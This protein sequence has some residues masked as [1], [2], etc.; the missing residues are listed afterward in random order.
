MSGA[1]VSVLSVSAQQ[2]GFSTR[3]GGTV[4]WAPTEASLVRG[5]VTLQ[6]AI[7]S[8]CTQFLSC[9]RPILR[10]RVTQILGLDEIDDRVFGAVVGRLQSLGKVSELL[11]FS[12]TDKVFRAYY[13]T[14]HRA[15]ILDA[16]EA[17]RKLLSNRDRVLVKDLEGSLFPERAY[18]T[19]SSAQ[20]ILGHLSF[21]G[22]A[23]QLDNMTFS[24]VD[25]EGLCQQRS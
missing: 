23:T 22:I 7:E 17:G 11:V 18:N 4:L 9:A 19:W 2:G 12:K 1:A 10:A 24:R 5:L 13:S 14:S 8:T 15:R 16:I 3:F 25:L 21:V 20:H 6:A